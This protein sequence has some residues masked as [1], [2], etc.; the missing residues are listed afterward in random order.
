MVMEPLRSVHIPKSAR[1]MK[2]GCRMTPHEQRA[3]DQKYKP[4]R[5]LKS[6]KS[7][8]LISAPINHEM[9]VKAAMIM[10]MRRSSLRL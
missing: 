1:M 9:P 8:V 2:S 4:R 3:A 10:D 6:T 7:D 5:R